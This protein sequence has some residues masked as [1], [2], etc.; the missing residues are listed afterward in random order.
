MTLHVVGYVRTPY[1]TLAE[2]PSTPPGT[3]ER[4]RIEILPEYVSALE[5]IEAA[6]H[7]VV[8]YWLGE[9]D[10]EALQAVTRVD[11]RVRGVFANRAPT[12]PNPLAVAAVP[13]H[14][15]EADQL[16]VGG[17]DCLDRTPLIDLKPYVPGLDSVPDATVEWMK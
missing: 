9:A 3:E 10:R 12:R 8:L 1:R 13:L 5:G 4:S 14:A 6:S 15:R 11:G 2:C 7:L 16:V 17:L